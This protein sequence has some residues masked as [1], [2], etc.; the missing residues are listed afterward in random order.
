MLRAFEFTGPDRIP[1]VYHPS[2]AGLYVH[3]DRLLALFNRF[4]PDNP[5]SFSIPQPSAAC[6][7]N[8]AY[9]EQR[10]D[11][12]GT[13][14]ECNIVGIQGHAREH[15]LADIQRIHDYRFPAAPDTDSAAG[16]AEHERV[17]RLKTDY[18]LFGGWISLLERMCALRP[19][20][21]V[22]VDIHSRDPQ[23]MALLDRLTDYMATV[24][25]YAVAVGYD[26]IAFGD[27]WG[28]QTGPVI[29]PATFR[30]VFGEHYARLFRIAHDAGRKVFFHETYKAIGGGGIFYVEIENDAPFANV[31]ALIESVHEFR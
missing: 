13:L 18:L 1:V 24:A 22:L 11:E 5:V 25:A 8:G 19:M 20:Q 4:P 15:P 17:A 26:V 28:F 6:F 2:P 9:R 30:E 12:W 31:Q 23:F 10:R 7:V 16:R 21:D 3:G 27:D 29:S 14:W